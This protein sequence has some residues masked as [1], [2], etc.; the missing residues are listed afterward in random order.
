[1][2]IDV[3]IVTKKGKNWT[4]AKSRDKFTI[5]I[6]S[7]QYSKITENWKGNWTLTEHTLFPCVSTYFSCDPYIRRYTHWI[8]QCTVVV[9]E[10]VTETAAGWVWKRSENIINQ[11]STAG[12]ENIRCTKAYWSV[13]SLSHFF[14]HNF[15]SIL[16]RG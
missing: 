8:G 6:Y 12:W 2:V 1:M 11:L 5:G 4:T 10:M 13:Q 15:I 16:S 3:S 14:L 7:L 9:Y